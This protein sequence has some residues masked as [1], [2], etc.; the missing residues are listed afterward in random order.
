MLL[1][2]GFQCVKPE[3]PELEAAAFTALRVLCKAETDLERA[4]SAVVVYG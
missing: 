1:V 3:S 4:G 2:A